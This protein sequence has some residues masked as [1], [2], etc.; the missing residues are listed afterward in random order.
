MGAT[1]FS[2]GDTAQHRR[3]R[4]LHGLDCDGFIRVGLKALE[5]GGAVAGSEDLRPCW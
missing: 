1:S 2:Q 4:G 5:H 3:R